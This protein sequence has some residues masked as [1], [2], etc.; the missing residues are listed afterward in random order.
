MW[1]WGYFYFVEKM[2][3][4]NK[5]HQIWLGWHLYFLIRMEKM[6]KTEKTDR[7]DMFRQSL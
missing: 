5:P 7:F 4:W 6:E 1:G 2:E 3:K